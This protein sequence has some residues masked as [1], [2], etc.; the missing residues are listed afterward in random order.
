MFLLV[1]VN[2]LVPFSIASVASSNALLVHLHPMI[3]GLDLLTI[4]YFLLVHVQNML[5]HFPCFYLV[6]FA[7]HFAS[8]DAHST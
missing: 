5:G 2:E 4:S 7:I 8:Y 1:F 6:G 3:R